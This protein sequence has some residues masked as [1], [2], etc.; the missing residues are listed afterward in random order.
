MGVITILSSLI[1]LS[2]KFS[3][4]DYHM[5]LDNTDYS[6]KC[7]LTFSAPHVAREVKIVY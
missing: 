1:A 6:L 2:G 5:T 3:S 4:Q 7:L